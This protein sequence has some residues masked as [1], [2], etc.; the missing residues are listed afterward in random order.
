MIRRYLDVV[1]DSKVGVGII[2]LGGF[3]QFLKREWSKLDNV[4]IV[5]VSDEDPSRAADQQDATFYNDYHELLDDPK[6]DIVSI[7]TPPSTHVP[8]ALAAIEKGKNLL[9]EK[10]LALSAEDGRKIAEA[11]KEAG[12][13][14]TV[15]FM[16]RFDPIVEG[17]RKIVADRVFGKPRRVDLRNYATQ[18]TVPPGHWFWNQ[19]ISG[20]I[21][22]EH[23]VHFFDMT[24]YILDSW[25][26]EATGVSVWRNNEQE[27]RMFATVKFDD[28][29]VGTY[30]HSFTRPVALETTNFHMAFDLGEVD[31]SGWIPLTASF[32]GWTDNAGIESIRANL[33]NAR[34]DI[35]EVKPF[36]TQSS[37]MVYRINASIHGNAAID[38]PK[39]DVYGD[40]V[41]A[42]LL[43]VIAATKDPNHKLR[44]SLDDAIAAVAIAEQATEAAHRGMVPV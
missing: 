31:I 30:W 10:P 15:N 11:A 23:G 17:M 25:A 1:N 37:E 44:V 26:L 6:V 21:L 5:A 42:N 41:R 12:V 4:R 22:I 34:V 18:D 16:L 43:D 27:D 33:P 28:G 19:D 14:A 32:W 7:A 29:V 20:G 9:I 40:L 8:M 39:G 35:E 24:S 3:G 36:D 38:K 13:V 2:G